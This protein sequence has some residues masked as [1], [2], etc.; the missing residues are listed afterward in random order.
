MGFAKEGYKWVIGAAILTFISYWLIPKDPEIILYFFFPCTFPFVL[1]TLFMIFFFRD[2]NR[3]PDSTFDPQLSITSPADGSLCAIEEEDGNMALY[4]EMHVSGVHVVRAHIEG[5]V[6]KISRMQGKHH[7]IYFLKKNTDAS[8]QAI[9]KNARVVIE[10]EDPQGRPFL[11]HM[12]CGKLARRAVPYVKV[13][14]HIV[15]GQRMGIIQFGS[16]I[17][18]TLPGTAY[19]LRKNISDRVYGGKSILC[20]RIVK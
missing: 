11:Y 13:G 9:R 19:Q 5:I 14:D 8:S 12:V 18:I 1:L 17:K 3:E 16:L 7:P 10:L 6:K 2:P 4:V 20:D 15:M